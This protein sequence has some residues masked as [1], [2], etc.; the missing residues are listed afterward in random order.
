MYNVILASVLFFLF[1]GMTAWM[2]AIDAAMYAIIFFGAVSLI[3]FIILV[4]N[5]SPFYFGFGRV[6]HGAE[7]NFE[8][9]KEGVIYHLEGWKEDD[10][11]KILIL[12]QIFPTEEI[13]SY[14]AL[15]TKYLRIPPKYF[16][17]NDEGDPIEATP[18]L[19][20][21]DSSKP[22]TTGK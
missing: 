2:I 12:S 1:E 15:R 18:P 8:R 7:E 10:G 13:R 11:N 6:T 22:M 14:F 16:T 4:L 20:K 19:G 21:D 5:V 17:L 3:T 9:L